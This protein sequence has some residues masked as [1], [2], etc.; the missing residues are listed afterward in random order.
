MLTFVVFLICA[1]ISVSAS[2][3]GE[4]MSLSEGTLGMFRGK[5]SVIAKPD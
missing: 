4:L 3:K 5:L 2:A 1:A